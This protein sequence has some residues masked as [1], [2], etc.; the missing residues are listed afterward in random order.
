MADLYATH[1]PSLDAPAQKAFA[2]TP[3]DNNDLSY[4]MRIVATA[5]RV[6]ALPR[7]LRRCRARRW[8]FMRRTAFFRGSHDRRGLQAGT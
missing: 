8:R 4:N 1:S 6:K 5:C 3:D 2:I 7:R